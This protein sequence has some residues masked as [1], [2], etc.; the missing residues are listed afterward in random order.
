MADLWDPIGVTSCVVPCSVCIWDIVRA[1]NTHKQRSQGI[2]I[3]ALHLPPVM[4]PNRKW[5][6][7]EYLY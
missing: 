2:P 4:F 3:Q 1:T 5:F 7:K 6:N